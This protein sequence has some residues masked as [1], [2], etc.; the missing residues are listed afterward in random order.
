MDT[1]HA[2]QQE[3]QR[4]A[5]L[6]QH[7][8]QKHRIGIAIIDLSTAKLEPV[9]WQRPLDAKQV[10]LLADSI[11]RDGILHPD[12]NR[13]SAIWKGPG[14]PDLSSATALKNTTLGVF[15]GQ[16]RA[17]AVQKV[18]AEFRSDNQEDVS[19]EWAVELYRSEVETVNTVEL[20]AAITSDNIRRQFKVAQKVLSDREHI[21]TVLSFDS[22]ELAST[23]ARSL[24][25]LTQTLKRSIQSLVADA[26][27]FGGIQ[28]IYR[29]SPD[30]VR[31]ISGSQ[32]KELYGWRL[33]AVCISRI[34]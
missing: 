20:A 22:F 14:L 6:A 28:S 9:E 12:I 32:G 21:S 23:Y 11:R 19:Y 5:F 18:A 27:C 29:I 8:V 13:L 3:D 4:S 24:T 26:S 15:I 10:N 1:E 7:E 31:G 25:D 34:A 17:H 30:L 2:L 33:G 16:H